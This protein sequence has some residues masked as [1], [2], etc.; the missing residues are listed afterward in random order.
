MSPDADRIREVIRVK[1][2]SNVQ[3][4]NATG[5]SAATLSHITSGRSNPT[6]T[7]MR[8]I[9]KGFP[10]LNPMWVY[11]GEGEMF[12]EKDPEQIAEGN[13]S[14]DASPIPIYKDAHESVARSGSA[15]TVPAA[16]QPRVARPASAHP[17]PDLFGGLDSLD[18]FGS[19][20]G[21]RLAANATVSDLV[22]ETIAQVQPQQRRIRQITEIRIFFD[23]GTYESFGGPR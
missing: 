16:S 3:F 22:R 13:P 11:S 8:S 10:D 6:L 9:I 20:V 7:I 15:D 12:R 23:D 14:P 19:S 18:L 1:G 17:S 21:S 5:V 2:L 4:C